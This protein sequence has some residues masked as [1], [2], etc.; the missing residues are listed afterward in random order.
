[1]RSSAQAARGRILERVVERDMAFPDELKAAFP[2]YG[3]DWDKA[4]NEGVDVSM[5]LENLRLSPWERVRKMEA[6]CREMNELKK[7]I[8]WVPRENAA[9]K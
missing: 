5:L 9:T 1:M 2:S 3:P 6:W 7:I 8:R 4:V